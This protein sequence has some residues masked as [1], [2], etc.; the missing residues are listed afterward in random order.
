LRTRWIALTFVAL[1]VGVV[2]GSLLAPAP[3]GGV[4]KEMIQLQQSVDQLTQGQQALRS[5]IDADNAS[6]QTLIKQALD[7]VTQLNTQMGSLQ[8]SVQ[9]VQANTGSRLDTMSTQTQGVSDNMAD[10][11]ARVA[12]LGQQINDMQS[13]LQSI[14]AKVSGNAPPSTN[15]PGGVPSGATPAPGSASNAPGGSGLPP[16]S[17]DTLYQNALRDFT[18]GNYDLSRQEFSDYIKN[19][20]S[21]D[22]AG[23]A[24]F[25]LGEISYVQ[26]NFKGAISAYNLVLENYPQSFKLAASLLK[27]SYAELELGE[28]SSAIRDLREVERRF[29]GSDES[30]RAQAKLRELGATSSRS[31]AH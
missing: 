3:A 18:S 28:K 17:A 10:M 29:P 13:L 1:L 4:S 7:A 23:N 11:Q 15:A 6:Q 31:P 12:K 5:A 27:R 16:I 24:Q 21:N 20:P 26:N 8:Q 30:R 19:F 2:A 9:Q 14:D 22:L 25:Y